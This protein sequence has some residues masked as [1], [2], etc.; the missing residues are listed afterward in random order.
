[1]AAVLR[2]STPPASR[3]TDDVLER[4]RTMLLAEL[5]TKVAERAE[6]AA[7][8][9]SLTGETDTDSLLERELAEVAASRAERAIAEIEHAL[10]RI[11]HGTYGSCEACGAPVAAE[12][13]EVIPHVRYCIACS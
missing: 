3:L 13:L 10:A 4:L 6:H 8:A 5:D 1:M 12:R 2:P 11:D 7:R 9:S